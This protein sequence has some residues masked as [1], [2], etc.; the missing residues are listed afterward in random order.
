MS[1]LYSRT[2]TL[3]DAD[4]DLYRRLRPSVLLTLQT[5]EL[6]LS[7]RVASRE[8]ALRL[9]AAWPEARDGVLSL[10]RRAMGIEEK[11]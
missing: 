10:W 4:V 8:E 11:L 6:T 5:G 7:L 3:R 1:E 9:A 2:F